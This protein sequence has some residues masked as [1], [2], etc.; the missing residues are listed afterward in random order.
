MVT[1]ETSV[2]THKRTQRRLYGHT[3]PRKRPGGKVEDYLN[4]DPK[5][6]RATNKQFV[7]P[8]EAERRKNIRRILKLIGHDPRTLS[9]E[10]L[11]EI[12]RTGNTPFS[13]GFSFGNG[14][15]DVH[16]DHINGN[17]KEVS[18]AER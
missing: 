13:I 8:E 17:G 4:G 1:T 9:L 10:S 15:S 12:Y 11:K 6:E 7:T 14:K 3:I 16:I 18:H 5:D 2:Q